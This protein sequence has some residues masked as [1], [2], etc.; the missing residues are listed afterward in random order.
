MPYFYVETKRK[1]YFEGDRFTKP[2]T[3]GD[4]IRIDART[5]R[6]FA[7]GAHGLTSENARDRSPIQ[8]LWI[9]LMGVGLLNGTFNLSACNPSLSHEMLVLSFRRDDTP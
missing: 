3:D 2:H 4:N 5:L 9:G 8:M 6:L 1:V 7:T